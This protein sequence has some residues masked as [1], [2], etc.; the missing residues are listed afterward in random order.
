MSAADRM[1]ENK[2]FLLFKVRTADKITLMNA[3]DRTYL[4][5]STTIN[6]L[7]VIYRCKI[8]LDNYCSCRAGLFTLAAGNTTVLTVHSNL[9][10]LVVII[11]GYSNTR[12]VTNEVNNAVR[13]FLNA[14]S[15]AYAFSRIDRGNALVIYADSITGA[16]LYAVTVA[17]AGESA[18][19]I[20]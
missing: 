8:V 19:V 12:S 18:E 7:F 10:A 6:T 9:S 15:A 17:E 5:A 13:A 14:K 20:A 3:L 11:T 16:Y 1:T 2:S 4:T